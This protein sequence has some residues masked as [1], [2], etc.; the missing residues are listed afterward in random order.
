[1]K[2]KLNT[3]TEI[4]L[5][6]PSVN[7]T[8][9]MNL[10][11]NDMIDVVIEHQVENLSKQLEDIRLLI[12]NNIKNIK[13]LKESTIDSIIS[14]FKSED[15]IIFNKMVKQYNLT[16]KNSSNLSLESYGD[17]RIEIGKY[18]PISIDNV[19]NYKD[20]Y[21]Y[22]KRHI[23]DKIIY[24][25]PIE[26][27][28]LKITASLDDLHIEYCSKISPTKEQQKEYKSKILPLLKLSLSLEQEQ[29]KLSM[30]Y[31]EYKYGEKR[32][33]AKI[34]KASLQ[35]SEEG[36]GILAMLE[37]ATNIKLLS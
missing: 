21:N 18:N 25:E 29:S 35:K 15:L 16:V 24:F 20:P 22:A 2:N 12:D 19:E 27:C 33:K 34:V 4:A 23:N 9:N 30:L 13:S 32:I 37:G 36:R 5:S 28:K 17:S 6:N 11:Q 26:E 10:N 1:M 14:T 3:N 7:N 31:L 8:I